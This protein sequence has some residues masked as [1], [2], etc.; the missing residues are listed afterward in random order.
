MKIVVLDGQTLN[1]GDNPWDSISALGE[2]VIHDRTP[3][4]QIVSRAAEAEI[5][6]TN[7]TPLSRETLLALPKLKFI[8]VLA[9]GHNIVDGATARERGIPVSNVPSYSTDSV[10]QHTIAL[11]LE[12]CHRVGEHDQTVHAGDWVN[13]IDFCYWKSPL[14]QL[15]GQTLGIIGFGRI[16]QRVAEIARAL[17]MK[18]IYWRKP[19]SKHPV[20]E[21]ARG[22]DLPELCHTADVIS[23]HCAFTPQNTGFVNREFLAQLKPSAFL[24]NTARGAL[25]N[26]ADLAD[27]LK[28]GVLAGAALDVLSVEPPPAANPL[29]AAPRCI[30]T[31]HIAWTSL[32]ARRSLMR[33]TE[34]N[35]RAF[36]QGAPCNVV[37]GT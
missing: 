25:I 11:L 3:R 23:L 6:L 2:L 28:A 13:S 33:T 4:D 22:V 32:P 5:V 10:A 20:T 18:I 14:L 37:N 24:I 30:I 7:K 15:T 26:E 12:L 35:I 19:D 36:V 8:S 9:T 1:P 16:G 31:P 29:L 21:G 34:E 17:G 27:A